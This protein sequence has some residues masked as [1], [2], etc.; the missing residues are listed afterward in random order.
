MR[1]A[2]PISH[3]GR[4]HRRIPQR[5]PFSS[6]PRHMKMLGRPNDRPTFI[7]DTAGKQQPASGSQNSVSVDHEGLLFVE[8]K[9]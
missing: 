4:A 1:P 8:V 3:P 7:N 6:R 9:W 5:P 2:R